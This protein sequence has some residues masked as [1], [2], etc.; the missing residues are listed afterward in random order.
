MVD[1]LNTVFDMTTIH[2]NDRR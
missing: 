2:C 1:S